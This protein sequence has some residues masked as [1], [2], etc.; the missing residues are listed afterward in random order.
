MT[1]TKRISTKELVLCG[2]FAAILCISAYLSVPTPLPMAPKI[3][4]MNFVL[5]IIALLFPLLESVLIGLVWFLLGIVGLPVFI[6]GQSGIG[7]LA[8]PYGAY[9]WAFPIVLLVL[10]LIRGKKYNRFWYSVC[11]IIGVVIIDLVGMIWLMHSANYD[12][13]TGLL[14]GFVPFLPLDLIKAVVAA[15]LIPAFKR[16]ID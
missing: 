5:F 8:A 12:L 7:Y 1:N 14:T 3:T 2:L 10:P 9:T 13:K 16:V 15:Q 6:G 4:M 11:A